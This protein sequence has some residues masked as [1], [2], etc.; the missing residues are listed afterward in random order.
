MPFENLSEEKANAYF[1]DGVQD[2]ILT[3]LARVADLKVISRTS[4]I[5]YRETANRNLRKIGQELGVAH[6]LEGS[7]QRSGN[8]IRVNAQLIDARSDAHL[9]GQ[10]YDRDL[11][12]VFAIQSEI[13][14]AIANQLQAKLSP[15]ENAAIDRA[16]TKDVIAF[17]LYTRAKTLM[18]T[19]SFGVSGERDL[20]QAVEFLNQAIARDQQFFQAYCQLATAHDLVYFLGFDRTPS[21][22]SQAEKA[23]QMAFRLRPDAGETHLVRAENLY[24][25]HLDYEG[26]L[27]EL[28]IARQTLPNDVRILELTGY[29]LRRR[30]QLEEGL[31]NLEKAVELDPRNYFIM[32]QTA[33]SYNF[34]RRYSQADAILDRAL[35]IVP[36]NVDVRVARAT[37]DFLWKADTRLLHETIDSILAETPNA[38]ATSA[39]GWLVCGLAERDP[40]ATERALEA[41]GDNRLADSNV[42]LSRSV[43]EGLLARMLKNETR[44]REAF[45]RARAEQEKLVQIQ[46]DY[47]PSLCVL[48]LIDAGLGNKEAA[49]EEGRHAV[50]LLPVEKDALNGP[51][52]RAY[53]AVIA[54]W[55]D[56]KDLALEQLAFAT[57]HSDSLV[58]SYG[59]LRLLPFWDPLRGDPRF[60]KIVESLAPKD[61]K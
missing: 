26:A 16:P 47:G 41:L 46:P 6:L 19:T 12:D 32:Q 8:R 54:A 42:L 50:V 29:I 30:G 43:G 49:L 3:D 2:E 20:L 24:R 21:R 11:T 38:I 27:A 56:E 23:V 14:T 55:I 15:N 53:L 33:Q 9:W 17:D 61:A 4:V 1:A 10:T 44:A 51:V 60:E 5:S 13:A 18:L 39:D 28:E 40:V 36:K 58:A 52:L 25:G 45:T 35:A 57:A 48:A 59:G 37:Q 7:V 34:L 22:L 31:H